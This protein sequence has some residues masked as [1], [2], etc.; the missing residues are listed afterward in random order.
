MFRFLLALLA[1]YG[2][3]NVTPAH[4]ADEFS[5]NNP[6]VKKYEFAR[7]YITALSYMKDIDDRWDKNDPQEALCQTKK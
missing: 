3:M 1:V 6:D 5:K 7:S 2:M 4:A